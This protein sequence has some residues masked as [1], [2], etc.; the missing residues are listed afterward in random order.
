MSL[1]HMFI[2]VSIPVLFYYL[3]E[4]FEKAHHRIVDTI[5]LNNGTM[6]ELFRSEVNSIATNIYRQRTLDEFGCGNCHNQNNN[7]LPKSRL[8]YQSFVCFLENTCR[9][10]NNP[11]IMPTYKFDED[12]L[13]HIFAEI[14]D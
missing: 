8:T 5:S 13:R 7:A 4:S 11:N 10:V 14:Y 6:I 1:K 9:W 2:I 12:K 3:S